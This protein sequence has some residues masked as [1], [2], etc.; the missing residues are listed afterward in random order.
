MKEWEG[1]IE[2]CFTIV[3][4]ADNKFNDK[5]LA[6]YFFNTVQEGTSAKCP[7]SLLG[8]NVIKVEN[9]CKIILDKIVEFTK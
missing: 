2:R 4:Y 6:E 8:E 1:L 3:L 5:G 7:P 9:D